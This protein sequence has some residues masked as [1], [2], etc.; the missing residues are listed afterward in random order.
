MSLNYRITRY[1]QH[2]SNSDMRL[3]AKA[4]HPPHLCH[5]NCNGI[6]IASHSFLAGS[7]AGA[8]LLRV[9]WKESVKDASLCMIGRL[10]D[11]S[12]GHLQGDF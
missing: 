11:F 10:G 5:P 2:Y 7:L 8:R 6:E 4:M 12:G 9:T 3:A 1:G